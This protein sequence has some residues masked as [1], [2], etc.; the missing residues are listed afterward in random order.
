M[1]HPPSSGARCCTS[2][3]AGPAFVRGGL[4]AQYDHVEVARVGLGRR[5]ADAWSCGSATAPVSRP[6]AQRTPE[7]R[8]PEGLP[9]SL[10][11]RWV[12][13]AAGV[14]EA[15][16]HSPPGAGVP[17]GGSLTLRMRRG[18]CACAMGTAQPQALRPS[19]LR[20]VCD[21]WPGAVPCTCAQAVPA[22]RAAPP[23]MAFT[24]LLI[25]SRPRR[26]RVWLPAGPARGAGQEH[27]WSR[28]HCRA[29]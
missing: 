15:S 24:P 21:P 28:L 25:T 11:R 7:A 4:W 14:G 27:W 23:A 5:C 16:L 26:L 17:E 8:A 10:S 2:R 13:C 6:Q 9:G 20:R 18:S 22:A 1:S 12:S 3:A 19:R 29:P